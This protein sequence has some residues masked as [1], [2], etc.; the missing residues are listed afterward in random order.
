MVFNLTSYFIKKHKKFVIYDTRKFNTFRYFMCFVFGKNLRYVS[1]KHFES[2]YAKLALKF[3]K[4]LFMASLFLKGHKS[5]VDVEGR[6][7]WMFI[8]NKRF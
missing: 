4:L 3:K 8:N 2:L 1:K 5:S 6:I 7:E